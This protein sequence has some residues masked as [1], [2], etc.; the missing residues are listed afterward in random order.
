MASNSDTVPESSSYSLSLSD[1]ALWNLVPPGAGLLPPHPVAGKP[2]AERDWNRRDLTYY[3]RTKEDE[4]RFAKYAEEVSAVLKD[5]AREIL[6]ALG[7]HFANEDEVRRAISE[8]TASHCEAPSR[9]SL[10]SFNREA[11]IEWTDLAHHGFRLLLTEFSDGMWALAIDGERQM[12]DRYVGGLRAAGFTDLQ[13][14][15]AT[16]WVRPVAMPSE[17][18][19]LMAAVMSADIGDESEALSEAG[20]TQDEPEYGKP[21]SAPGNGWFTH[22]EIKKIF[23]AAID[24]PL[25]IS[26]CLVQLPFPAPFKTVLVESISSD[27]ETVTKHASAIPTPGDK[28][29]GTVGKLEPKINAYT[30]YTLVEIAAILYVAELRQ[31]SVQPQTVSS[32]LNSLLA[33]TSK[34]KKV[35]IADPS[36]PVGMLNSGAL[37][38]FHS[39][40]KDYEPAL[41]IYRTAQ[42]S[43]A[44]RWL[45][46]ANYEA[47]CLAAGVRPDLV[48]KEP[49]EPILWDSL[50]PAPW[51]TTE[52]RDRYEREAELYR[53]ARE[54]EREVC[55]AVKKL[56]AAFSGHANPGVGM[57]RFPAVADEIDLPALVKAAESS[58]REDGSQVFLAG[59]E[60]ALIRLAWDC[61]AIWFEAHPGVWPS[62]EPS[63]PF[64]KLI[65]AASLAVADIADR[66][67]TEQEAEEKRLQSSTHNP[68][69]NKHTKSEGKAEKGKA[70]PAQAKSNKT[71]SAEDKASRKSD[72]DEGDGGDKNGILLNRRNSAKKAMWGFLGQ[73]EHDSLPPVAVMN[74]ASAPDEH[75]MQYLRPPS[76]QGSSLAGP[77][78]WRQRQKRSKSIRR[79]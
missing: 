44:I 39:V 72:D 75:F 3:F 15:G 4:I 14:K 33:L 62:P 23:P 70:N 18:A 42:G 22:A 1:R 19:G 64:G 76:I 50:A 32:Y 59:R 7:F 31:T 45:A 36:T 2:W 5:N 63:H 52:D 77:T 8:R 41:H 37:E 26:E 29:I 47:R 10:S 17:Q 20:F 57:V 65:S 58:L 74:P 78:L 35:N 16:S 40:F 25:P 48:A 71:K 24:R 79:D 53:R 38:R 9:P 60:T 73:E 21:W 34:I 28:Q 30:A 43:V 55:R 13:T 66:I 56:D 69:E 11:E 54:I 12:P 27:G 6:E 49:V 51:E 46:V 61:L 67:T 68:Q